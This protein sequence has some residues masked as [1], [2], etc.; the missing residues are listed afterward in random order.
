MD[1]RTDAELPAA[2]ADEPAARALAFEAIAQSQRD[3]VDEPRF[4]VPAVTGAERGPHGTVA[5][6]AARRARAGNRRIPPDGFA[7]LLT[8]RERRWSELV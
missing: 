2:T 8:T 5:I 3:A 6:G 1:E 7:N 4:P